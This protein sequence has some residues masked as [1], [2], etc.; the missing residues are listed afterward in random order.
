MCVCDQRVC[1]CMHAACTDGTS[2]LADV[3]TRTLLLLPPPLAPRAAGCTDLHD[4][5]EA[6]AMEACVNHTDN[7][8][9][10]ARQLAEHLH[11]KAWT[12]SQAAAAA[13]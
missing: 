6:F 8:L 4:H 2:M 1:V 9:T 11:N 12:Q 13:T 3:S 5:E 7:L 10:L